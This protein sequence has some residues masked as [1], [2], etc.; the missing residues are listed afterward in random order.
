MKLKSIL[1]PFLD[2]KT[3][4]PA[5]ETA[6]LLAR[7]SKGHLSCV[8]IRQRPVPSTTVIY[9]LGGVFTEF[10]E[11]FLES[12]NKLA[13]DLQALFNKLAHDAKIGVSTLAKHSCEKGVTASWDDEADD[14]FSAMPRIAMTKDLAIFVGVGAD[15][16]PV[17]TMLAEE[18]LFQSG[19]P[20][21][22]CPSAGMLSLPKRITVAWN[23]RQEA[24]RAVAAAL[25]LLRDAEAVN[26][27]T[28]R[29]AESLA[30]NTDEITD[31]LRLHDVEAT[32]TDIELADDD[33]ETERLDEEIREFNSDLLVMGAYSHNRWREAILGGFTRHILKSSTIPV[34]MSQ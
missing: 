30:V 16:P 14:V 32:Q 2:E 28:V 18:L 15:A 22:L 1:V 3:A 12:E 27:L 24:A 4:G 11:D 5:F 34:F 29:K 13:N 10:T 21:L 7:E 17:A 23:G 25:D 20:Q 33:G 31:Y 19:R 26:V 8:H 6:A 9:P